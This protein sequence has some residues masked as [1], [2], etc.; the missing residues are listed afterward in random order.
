MSYY[1]SD[2]DEDREYA[3]IS[4]TTPVPVSNTIM[5]L[6]PTKM[7]IK[8]VRSRNRCFYISNIIAC[9]CVIIGILYLVGL[10][11]NNHEFYL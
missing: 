10:G 6:K 2:D 4:E 9:E 5:T 7:E 1:L 8:P 11:S 3:T